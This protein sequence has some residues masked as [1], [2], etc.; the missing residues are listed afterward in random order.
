MRMLLRGKDGLILGATFTVGKSWPLLDM[1]VSTGGGATWY[2]GCTSCF[3][4][5]WSVKE[6]EE[7][8]NEE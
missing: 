7:L 1:I 8:S 2:V 5:V 3:T 4:C 6:D